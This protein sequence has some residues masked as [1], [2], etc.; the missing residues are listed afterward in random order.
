M[1]WI[2]LH[3]VTSNE[4]NVADACAHQIDISSDNLT[5]KGI[6][7]DMFK[8]VIKKCLQNT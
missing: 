3:F 1:I 5:T 8:V 2:K 7:I 6:T 4:H